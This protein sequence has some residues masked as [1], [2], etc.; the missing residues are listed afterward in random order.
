[1]TPQ[2]APISYQQERET[3]RGNLPRTPLKEKDLEKEASSSPAP[4]PTRVMLREERKLLPPVIDVHTPPSLELLLAYA[5]CRV[6]FFDDDFTR[7]WFHI[8]QDEFEWIDP[9]TDKP[10][11][12]W[13]ASF[14]NWRLNRKF[15]ET[16]RDPK[17]LMSPAARKAA[18]A[19][20]A[21]ERR[22]EAEDA[23]RNATARNPEAWLLCAERCANFREGRCSCGIA[24]PPPNQ[25]RPIPPEECHR[26]AKGG[27][28]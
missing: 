2:N 27:A 20:E 22:H 13:T 23:R 9:K 4:A 7:E 1:M 15:F 28:K 17:R 26:F 19:E 5:H 10:I 18:E 3:E 8:M 12:H 21:D 16:L 24:I 6:H 25:P 14:R 11:R